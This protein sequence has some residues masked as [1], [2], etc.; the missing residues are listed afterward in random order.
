[1]KTFHCQKH[2]VT[3][4]VNDAEVK[5]VDNISELNC[6]VGLMR[7]SKRC[8]GTISVNILCV[9]GKPALETGFID[10]FTKIIDEIN[11]YVMTVSFFVTNVY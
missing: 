1:M 2:R 4:L 10:A 8:N 9:G 11:T 3:L 5:I 6:E 7:F